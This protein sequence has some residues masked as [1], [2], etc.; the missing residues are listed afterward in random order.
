TGEREM[1]RTRVASGAPRGRLRERSHRDRGCERGLEPGLSH[2]NTLL[3]WL[4]LRDSCG[5]CDRAPQDLLDGLVG[6]GKWI[7][8]QRAF[9]VG[10]QPLVLGD[11]RAAVAQRDLALDHV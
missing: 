10:A 9:E 6:L 4:R 2:T 1:G 8:V 11:G 3:R 7:H 5:P